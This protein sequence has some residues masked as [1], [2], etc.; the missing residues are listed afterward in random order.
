[1]DKRDKWNLSVF[2]TAVL[3]GVVLMIC[4]ALDKPTDAEITVIAY[5]QEQGILVSEYPESLIGL[6]DRYPES[7][8]FVLNYPFR[9]YVRTDLSSYDRSKGVPLFM[10][11]DERWGYLDYGG[12]M[13]ATDGSAALCLAMAGF[14][15]TGEERF[16]P[17]NVARLAV[18]KGYDIGSGIDFPV[19][20][21]GGPDLG[22][23][24]KSVAAAEDKLARYLQSGSVVIAVMGPGDFT[25]SRQ[26]IVVSDYHDGMLT[27][28]DP[29]SYV[30]SGKEW[31][32]AAFA[33]QVIDLWVVKVPPAE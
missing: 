11:W 31:S 25:A 1:M 15:L 6:L 28:N 4:L 2:G 24:V 16:Y 12:G 27:V 20:T 21:K 17:S 3:M 32:F 22:L 30:N 26:C 19:I 18:E 14:Y 8:D 5:A 13:L 23:H 10:L 33:D 29:S 7:K 9:K